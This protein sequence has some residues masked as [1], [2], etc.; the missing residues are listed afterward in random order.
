MPDT[1]AEPYTLPDEPA[2]GFIPPDQYASAFVR[3]RIL[4][5]RDEV[6]RTISNIRRREETYVADAPSAIVLH[7]NSYLPRG[8]PLFP[9]ALRLAQR[10]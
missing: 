4:R 8:N 3:F 9:V 6:C 7:T 10:I 5:N 2:F 1:S